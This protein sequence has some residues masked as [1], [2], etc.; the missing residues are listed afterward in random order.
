MA[1]LSPPPELTAMANPEHLEIL[2]R[3]VEV[4]NKWREEDVTLIPNLEGTHFV[5]AQ[6]SHVNL[7]DAILSDA[8]FEDTNLSGADFIRADLNKAHLYH[9]DLSFADMGGASLRKTRL[10]YT[11]LYRA[12]LSYAELWGANFYSVNLSFANLSHAHLG[13]ST[14]NET[15]VSH[16]N[17]YE[18]DMSDMV[19]ANID[20]SEVKSLESVRHNGPS[21]IGIDTIYKSQ[22][23]IH[24][25]FLKGC[26][27]P[28][29]F[30]TYMRSLAV[31]PIQFYTCFI[32]FT[33]A[34]DPFSE[35]IY[36]DL[37]AKGVR[38]WRW[39]EDAKW[40]K[41]LMRSIDEAVRVY[42]RLIVVCSEQSLNSPAVIREIER[43][44]QKEDDLARQGKEGEVLF[45]I[46][47]D[48][49]IF[50]DWNHHRKADV[51]AKNVG[52]FRKWKEHDQYQKTFDRLLRDLKAEEKQA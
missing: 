13:G 45:P 11:N 42:D 25:R 27:V 4:W 22:G 47:L 2:K 49:Y 36:N 8:K 9:T 40:G 50:T 32:S 18:A 26:G 41:T 23:D 6:L 46:R 51:I 21:I 15:I 31:Q 16:A 24:E 37:Q 19:I 44:L 10:F 14:F 1:S 12:N 29:D 28:E 7:R 48:N 35:R 17:F 38:C 30:I 20:L 39:K 34:D 5:E 43:A 52:D 3:G 33:E